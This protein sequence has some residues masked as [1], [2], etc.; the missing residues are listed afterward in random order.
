MNREQA[1]DEW[2]SLT[3]DA[4]DTDRVLEAANQ[5]RQMDPETLSELEIMALIANQRAQDFIKT[6]TQHDWSYEGVFRICECG[7]RETL[8]DDY[9]YMPDECPLW[10]KRG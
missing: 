10:G 3:A 5:D 1:L 2:A 7:V 8:W 9:W 4:T 6:I